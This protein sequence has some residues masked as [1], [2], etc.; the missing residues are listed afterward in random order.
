VCSLVA[1]NP[2]WGARVEE[3]GVGVHERFVDLDQ[4]RLETGLRRALHP[5]V[6]ARSRVI[7]DRIRADTGAA[8]RAADL[9]E[10]AVRPTDRLMI[11]ACGAAVGGLPAPC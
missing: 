10:Q 4:D 1:D 5:D 2:F 8:G 9:V 7:G 6:I 11:G 3:V